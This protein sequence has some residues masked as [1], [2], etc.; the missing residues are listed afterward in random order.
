MKYLNLQ[1]FAE[2]D[3]GAAA[4]TTE[5]T[6]P[7]TFDELLK[8]TKHQA[9]FDRRVTK[10][11]ETAKNKWQQEAA[12]QIE[13]ARTEAEKLAKMTAEQKAQH[14]KE[15]LEKSLK[16]RETALTFR[17]LRTEALNTL[18]EKG[19]PKELIESVNLSSAEAC[20]KSL[21]GIEAAFRAAV[22]AGVE[23]RLKGKTPTAGGETKATGDPK[24]MNYQQRAELYAKDKATYKKLFGGE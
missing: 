5:T 10:A 24:T 12:T 23:E 2:Q 19:L 15:Q 16:D 3:A 18:N 21:E 20:Q 17:E 13:Q 9:E 6:A 4:E 14:E 11:L 1:L 22:Q 8:D 7:P